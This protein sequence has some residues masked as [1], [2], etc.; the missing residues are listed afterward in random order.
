MWALLLLGVASVAAAGHLGWLPLAG[1]AAPAPRAPA[2]ELESMSPR[3]LRRLPGL[4]EVRALAL[5]NDR[6]R[7]RGSGEPLRLE[8]LPGIG[9]VTALRVRQA[10]DPAAGTPSSGGRPPARGI[11]SPDPAAARA[12][13]SPP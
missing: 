13:Q 1:V 5:A 11:H 6:W 9:P 12:A 2:T 8:T 3:E 7:R 4:G 10:L